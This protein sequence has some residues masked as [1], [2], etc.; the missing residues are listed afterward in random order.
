[1]CLCVLSHFTH[2]W[3]F[4]TPWTVACQAPLCMGF[5]SQEY[6]SGFPF[7]SPG[8]L[9]DPVI[10]PGSPALQ[11]DSLLFEPLGKPHRVS[12]KSL[13][14]ESDRPRGTVTSHLTLFLALELP[15]SNSSSVKWE[16][17]TDVL[18]WFVSPTKFLCRSPNPSTSGRDCIWDRLFTG[19]L[20]LNLGTIKKRRGN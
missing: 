2:V 17:C 5:S 10:E 11:A 19:V 9:P 8:D 6:W 15:R 13:L 1:M 3:L 20:K 18:D 14:L 7:L 4:V 16:Y 12:N